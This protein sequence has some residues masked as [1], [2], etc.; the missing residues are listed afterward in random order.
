MAF[1]KYDGSLASET[2]APVDNLFGSLP[3]ETLTGGSSPT[4]LWGDQGR[5]LIGNSAS[6]TFFIKSPLDR[7]IEVAGGGTDKIVAWTQRQ[8]KQLRNIENVEVDGDKT[9]GAGNSTDNIVQGGAGSQQLYGGGGQDVLIGGAGADTFI[10]VKG[11]G[12]DVIQDFTPSDGDVVRLTAGYTSF[13][14]VQSHLS[15]VGADVKLDLGGGDATIFRNLNVSQLSASNFALQLDTSKIGAETFHDDFNGPLSLWDAQ[16]NPGGAWRPDFGYQ[17]SQGV[18]S[19]SLVSNGE[20][21]IYTSPYFRDHN[22]DFSVNPFTS[23]ADGTLSITAAPSTNSELFGYKY[24]SGMIST[25]PSFAQTYGY[26]EMRA[27][28]PTTAGAWPAFW[29]IPADGSWPPE[30]DVM[31]TLTG[32]P[33]TDYTTQ[34]S[35]LGG[36]NTAIG[37]ANFIP[38]SAGGYHTYGVLWTH[39]TLTWYVDGVQVFQTAT[40]ADMNKPMYMIANEALGGWSGTIDDAHMPATMKIDYIHAYALADGSSTTAEFRHRGSGGDPRHCRRRNGYQRRHRAGYRQCF[41]RRGSDSQSC[42]AGGCRGVSAHGGKRFQSGSNLR[43]FAAPCRRC[44]WSER[45]TE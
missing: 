14:Q 5:T 44:H 26:F 31:E 40:P 20:Q 18:G 3:I 22:G 9:Y 32:D 7:V 17:G 33:N 15:Q 8:P 35:G 45:R 16:S 43:C 34:H 29:L 30:L 2:I 11:Q 39:S 23:N 37:A 36:S 28:L 12:N 19:Y 10:I 13:S 38:D 27:E 21:E 42:L 6:D 41:G 24:T 25:A 1:F 4:G